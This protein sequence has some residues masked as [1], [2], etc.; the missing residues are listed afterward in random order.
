MVGRSN[1]LA[2]PEDRQ[3]RCDEK[4]DLVL[5]FLRHEVWSSQSILGAVMKVQSRAAAHKN[6]QRMELDGLVRR[7]TIEGLGGGRVTLWGITPH[8]QAMAFTPGLD[9]PISAYFEPSKVAEITIKHGLDMQLLR[10]QAEQHGWREWLNGDRLGKLLKGG[11]RPDAMALNPAGL[12]TAIEIERTIK[13][14]KRYEQILASYLMALKAEQ[15]QQVIWL[16]PTEDMANRLRA[17]VFG[18]PS[19]TIQRQRFTVDP[20]R[21]HQRLYFMSYGDWMRTHQ[22]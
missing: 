14:T 15:V 2:A 10:V 12:K 20:E 6:L 11:K 13:T 17:I 1:L 16:S 5:R 9:E 4:R 7:H 18:I 8:G 22:A 19:V 21:H 3:K